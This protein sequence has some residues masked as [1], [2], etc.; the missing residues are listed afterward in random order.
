M[1]DFIQSHL[2]KE[3][4]SGGHAYSWSKF[5]LIPQLLVHIRDVDS[6]SQKPGFFGI[7]EY[8]N[9]CIRD[10]EIL[11][12]YNIIVILTKRRTFMK[13]FQTAKFN[14]ILKN[15]K[16]IMLQFQKV[17]RTK[18]CTFDPLAASWNWT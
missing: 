8:R 10:P 11:N 17:G 9:C 15:L 1:T 13:N 16:T 7:S 4:Y 14:A 6:E 3:I 18:F 5:K 2:D 12:I